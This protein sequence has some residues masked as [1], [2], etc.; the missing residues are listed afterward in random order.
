M[1]DE[2]LSRRDIAVVVENGSPFLFKNGE[3]S[4]RRMR[5]FY[6]IETLR[7]FSIEAECS[8]IVAWA[9]ISIEAECSKIV[10]WANRCMQKDIIAKT[11]PDQK[12][13]NQW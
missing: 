8:K 3:E 2:L 5:S 4:V 1:A 9:N 13:L 10:A 6:S 11:L 7:G 12:K